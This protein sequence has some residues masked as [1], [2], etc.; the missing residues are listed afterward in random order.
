M[1]ALM[2]RK[3]LQEVGI[4]RPYPV[5]WERTPVL[6]KYKPLKL[7]SYDGKGSSNQ[8]WYYFLSLV[9]HLTEKDPMKTKIFTSTFERA[10]I[11]MT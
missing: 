1:E 10:N 6:E 8:N 2:H 7:E 3:D 5:E 4:T 11:Y 9:G